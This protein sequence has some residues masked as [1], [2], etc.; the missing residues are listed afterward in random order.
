ML[1]FKDKSMKPKQL[2]F[3]VGSAAIVLVLIYLGYAG[4]KSSMSYNQTVSEMLATKEIAYGRHI[5]L[6]GDVIPGTIKRE[7]RV[8]IFDVNDSK[9]KEKIV[10]IRY[11]GKDPLPDTF[12]DNAT[13]MAKGKLD[14]SGVFVATQMTAKCASKYDK[15][16]AAGINVDKAGLD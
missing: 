15:E 2:K 3:L 1:L 5:E 6:T 4:F 13:A 12:R 14:K 10:T 8:V 9:D 16:K 7:G 11:E